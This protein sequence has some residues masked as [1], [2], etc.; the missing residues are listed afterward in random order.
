MKQKS[1]S[2]LIHQVETRISKEQIDFNISELN[3]L[4]DFHANLRENLLNVE[5]F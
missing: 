5:Y 2:H 4:V 3:N 1:I